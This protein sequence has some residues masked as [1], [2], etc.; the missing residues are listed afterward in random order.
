[1]IDGFKEIWRPIVKAY[2]DRIKGT[3]EAKQAKQELMQWIDRMGTIRPR[4]DNRHIKAV[5]GLLNTTITDNRVEDAST[6]C[7][8]WAGG[9]EQR[10]KQVDPATH[11]VRNDVPYAN[12]ERTRF[13]PP[14][15]GRAIHDLDFQLRRWQNRLCAVTPPSASR[16]WAACIV[17]S[18]GS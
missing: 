1:M 5:V 3:R 6:W 13:P 14:N 8:A 10:C 17:R 9:L 18:A 2:V 15:M 7:D 4:A 12:V 16:C 11:R